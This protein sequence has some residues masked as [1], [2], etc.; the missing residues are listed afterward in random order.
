MICFGEARLAAIFQFIGTIIHAMLNFI[1]I[2]YLNYEVIGL[3]ISTSISSCINLCII[4]T[5]T[6]RDERFKQTWIMPRLFMFKNIGT[7]VKLAIPSLLML[8]LPWWGFEAHFYI[9]S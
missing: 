1:F 4:C 5:Y 9:A 2:K 3:A 6:Y 7:Y 8:C